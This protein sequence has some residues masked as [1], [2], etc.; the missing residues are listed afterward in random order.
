MKAWIIKLKEE[1]E[2]V[3][4]NQKD[5]SDEDVMLMIELAQKYGYIYKGAADDRHVFIKE[6]NI[7]NSRKWYYDNGTG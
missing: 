4:L 5:D 3:L 1:K 7:G 6:H 2:I